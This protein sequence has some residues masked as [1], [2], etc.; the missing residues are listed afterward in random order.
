M[1]VGQGRA[2]GRCARCGKWLADEKPQAISAKDA[3]IV[4]RPAFHALYDEALTHLKSREYAQAVAKFTEAIR[5]EPQSPNAHL[6]R[7]L[8]YRSMGDE[9]SAVRDEAA[10]RELG[11][12]ERSTWA[13]V[14]N[15]A[16]RLWNVDRQASRAE[17]YQGLHPLQRKAV[18]L[19]E[20]NGQVMN[21][22]FPQWLENG[23]GAWIGD[24]VDTLKQIGT[25]S[26]RAVQ[27]ILESIELHARDED[28]NRR[29]AELLA[30][31][32]RYYRIAPQFGTDVEA[33]LE[34]ELRRSP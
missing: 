15:R 4:S 5:L 10:A 25:D 22:G 14:V 7:A 11:G 2:D 1:V 33:W 23:H 6:G 16:G 12:A 13:S 27:S 34:A 26:A 9:A 24:V 28:A 17:F 18:Q 19:W 32:D 20:L 8:A 29:M 21:G 3:G 31:T 30:S